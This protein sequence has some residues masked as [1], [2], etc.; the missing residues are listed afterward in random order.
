MAYTAL[1]DFVECAGRPVD[2]GW[3]LMWVIRPGVIYN[4]YVN[5]V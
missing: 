5:R 3:I 4:G 1:P 2:M